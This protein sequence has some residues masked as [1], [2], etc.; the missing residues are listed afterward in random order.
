[1]EP[2]AIEIEV[3]D[4]LPHVNP[5][6]WQIAAAQTRGVDHQ[7]RNQD[8]EDV[9]SLAMVSPDVLVIVIADGAGSADYAQ[10]GASVAVGQAI[11]ELCCHL[12]SA[13]EPLDEISMKS[14]LRESM[15]AAR[16]AVESEAAAR[17]VSNDELATTLILMVARPEFVAV[18]QVGDGA[19]VIADQAGKLVGLTLPPVSEYINETTFLTSS[20]ALPTMQFVFWR[21]CATRLAAFS[22]GLQMLCLQWPERQPYEPFFSPLFDFISASIDSDEL[23]AAHTLKR[24]LSSERM[25]SET[26]DDLTLVLGSRNENAHEC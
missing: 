19:T 22:D 23:L 14:L 9:Y 12:T 8:C 20:Q 13:A 15:A 11:A 17:K 5:G 3:G 26:Y 1:M 25:K 7:T 24:F 10:V 16:D 18:A 2:A 21:G 6:L 4:L